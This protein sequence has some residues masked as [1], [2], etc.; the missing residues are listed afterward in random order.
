MKYRRYTLPGEHP[1]FDAGASL[2]PRGW[3]LLVIL[4]LPPIVG[5]IWRGFTFGDWGWGVVGLIICAG[6]TYAVWHG[7]LT[8]MTT[9]NNGVYCRYEKPVRYWLTLALWFGFYSM[10]V[11]VFFFEHHP[12]SGAVHR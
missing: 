7:L 10:T 12:S 6:F 3:P 11:A 9:C 5:Y 4:S 1:S 8:R 2:L